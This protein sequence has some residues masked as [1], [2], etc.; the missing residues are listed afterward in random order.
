MK[1]E[2]CKLEQKIDKVIDSSQ[3]D[4]S[5]NALKESR[6]GLSHLYAKEEKYW[7]QRSLSQWLREGDRNTCY[8]HARATGHLKK[9]NTDKVKDLNG[10]WVT[11][12]K[13]IC[14]VAKDYFCRLF[15][16]NFQCV[17]NHDLDYI[18]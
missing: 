5:A 11:N 18:Q 10:N 1:R 7:A 15:Q 9:N 16:S 17:D 12:N 13:E 2:I 6:C 14:N 3:R 8:L 4:D